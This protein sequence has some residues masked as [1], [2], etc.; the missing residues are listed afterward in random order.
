[1][2]PQVGQLS[3]DGRSIW[4]GAQWVANGGAVA[5]LGAIG[6][7][8]PYESSRTRMALLAIFL[9]AS[10]VSP[11]IGIFLDLVLI[12]PKTDKAMLLALALLPLI[13]LVALLVTFIPSIVFFC[14]WLHRVVRNMPA[15]GA[16]DPRWSPAGAV[17]R[18]FIPFLNLG[19]PMAGVLEAWRGSD[20]SRRW[21]NVNERKHLRVPRLMTAW[22]ACW[23]TGFWLS[24]IFWIMLYLPID[25]GNLVA[26]AVRHPVAYALTGVCG[27]V[28]TIIAAILAVLVVREVTARQD[29]K[30]MLITT[31]RL[32]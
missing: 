25:V 19:Y 6:W 5:T 17:G 8:R 26:Y 11:I 1:M 20:P 15:L 18:C 10:V 30:N 22:W 28:L 29:R 14:L 2:A 4:D 16:S 21:T 32:A 31:R 24:S 23:L 3:P 27:N 7:E 9:V 12:A 13:F